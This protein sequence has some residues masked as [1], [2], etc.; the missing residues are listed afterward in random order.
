MDKQNKTKLEFCKNQLE[1]MLRR[2]KTKILFPI[3]TY[4]LLKTYKEENKIVFT[5]EMVSSSY[6]NAVRFMKDYLKHEFHIG[7][8]YYDAYPSRNLPK[9]GVLKV[10]ENKRYQLLDPYI[11][12]TNDLLIWIPKRIKQYIDIK[13]GLIPKLADR[14]FRIKISEE[15]NTFTKLIKKHIDENANNFEIFSFAIIKVHLEK[16]A[17]K[18]YRDTRTSS[19]D[20]GTDISTNFGV[21]YQIKK[22]I[23]DNIG[24]AKNI[25]AELQTNFDSERLDDGKVV[26]IIDDI[27]KEVKSFLINMKIQSI[28][29]DDVLRLATQF[30]DVED[31]EKVLRII[32][33]E[34]KREYGSDIK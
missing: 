29:K 26:L 5:D 24:I 10:I 17:C 28:S 13:I 21:V 27:S 3:I 23:V 4:G 14:G 20:K 8:K 19:H 12:H 18:I 22:L 32:Y 34:F 30:E 25:Y 33:E 9:Y 6:K 11:T 7:G 1:Q 16:F 31:K 15:K 2:S